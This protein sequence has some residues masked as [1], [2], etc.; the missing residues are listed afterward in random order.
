VALIA[1]GLHFHIPR[2]YLY[3]AIAFSAGVEGLNL[4]AAAA[5]KRRALERRRRAVG[6]APTGSDS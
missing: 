6:E 4:W 2:G 3:F 5:R 1:D